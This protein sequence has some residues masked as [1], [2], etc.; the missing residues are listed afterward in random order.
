LASSVP[1]KKNTA[2]S[3]EVALPSQAGA[4]FQANPTLAAGD[5]VVSKD[6]GAF[7]NIASL[8][9]AISSGST[10]TV[11]LTSTEMNADRIVV[12]FHDV[13]GDEWCDVEC[14]IMTAAQTLDEMD[15]IIDSIL[16]DTAEIGTAGAG[17][18]NI[19]LPNQTMD[20]VG[21][22]TG[23]LSGSVGSVTGTVSA[24]VV[25]ISGDSAAA[26]NLELMFDGTGY[27][28][29]TAPA[30]R[31]QVA[32]ILTA[33]GA[34]IVATVVDDNA[35]G[36]DPLNGVTFVGSVASGT[37]ADTKAAGGTRLIID[38][39]TNEIDY[40]AQL[41]IPTN[42]VPTDVV[43]DGYVTGTNDACAISAYDF[44]GTAWVQ[45]AT[46]NGQSGTGQNT[47]MSIS[48]GEPRFSDSGTIYLRFTAISGSNP[49]LG[50]DRLVIG[51]V[52]QTIG[53]VDGAVWV[54][55]NNGT[56]GTQVFVN[57]TAD[58]PVDTLA[59]GVTLLGSL[60]LTR[61]HVANDST[62]TLA[63]T[64]ANYEFNGN[65]WVLSL[66]GQTISGSY[67][68]GAKAVVGTGVSTNASKPI[69]DRCAFGDCT[70][71][72]D[73]VI[74][75]CIFG[76]TITVASTAGV[77]ADLFGA[78][79][80]D[81]A[82][83]GG[84][85]PTFDFSG[86]TKTTSV[87]FR[88]WSG[89]IT[90]TVTS[91]CTVSVDAISGGTVTVNGTG[92]TVHVRGMVKVVDGSSGA[93]TIVQTQVV[94]DDTLEAADAAALAAYDGPTNTELTAALAAADDAILAILGTPADTDI[95]TDI[96]NISAGG[97]PTADQNADALLDRADAIETGVT[98]RQA[99]RGSLAVLFGKASG[100]GSG[101][102]TFRNAVAD[103]KDRVVSTNDSFGNRTAVT[104]DL[105]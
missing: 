4:V 26:D 98:V 87:H 35:S 94:N 77:T 91:D 60:G 64:S 16:T 34:G 71:S 43:F 25:S 90:L 23:N 105:T 38:D 51:Y 84:A 103:S 6:G 20:I 104:T 30:S 40:V 66:N 79:N 78:F 97:A 18:T 80:C 62:L 37:F 56:A 13:A 67:F 31:A 15:T 95:A 50:I 88:K 9:T 29:D 81:S 41:T 83:A 17:L 47:S 86:V 63:A 36:T 28:D 85:A 44:V 54:D 68:Y 12:K 49:Q 59:D 21:N 101:T 96:A 1:A 92:G 10:L 82:V 22:I 27:T 99:M 33:G 89:G 61:L 70:L 75:Y 55:T 5:V 8:P 52:N 73:I 76:G 11:A 42:A 48:L 69:F 7:S 57:G 102:E 2:Y 3:F 53:Y 14:L 74:G 19:N 72:A 58:L 45:V 32:G 93:V 100:G 46:L 39:T 24:D 65:G